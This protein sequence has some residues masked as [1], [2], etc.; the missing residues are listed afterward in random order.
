VQI[1]GK[2]RDRVEVPIDI[3]E[4]SLRDVVLRRPKVKGAT[5]FGIARVIVRAPRLVNVVPS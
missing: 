2:V 1:N 5:P 4:D 3:T